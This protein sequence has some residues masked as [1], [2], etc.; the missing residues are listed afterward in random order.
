MSA[1]LEEQGAHA[2]HFA[3]FFHKD[4]KIL[5]DDGDSQQDSGARADGAEE[6]RHYWQTT[7]AQAAK[8][9]SGGDIPTSHDGQ[10]GINHLIK[11]PTPQQLD[12]SL[13]WLRH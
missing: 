6:V 4:F 1:D 13:V 5:I 2:A 7:D 11:L 9:S 10:I 3:L 8:G 12:L